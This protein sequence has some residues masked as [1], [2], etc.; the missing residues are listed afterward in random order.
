[1]RQEIM[2]RECIGGEEH[3]WRA[4]RHTHPAEAGYDGSIIETDWCAACGLVRVRT[5]KSRRL[6][7]EWYE[8][9]TPDWD[10][11][12]ER[13][14]KSEA[15]W[16]ALTEA[17]WEGFTRA[18]LPLLRVIRDHAQEVRRYARRGP[19]LAE[20]VESA[21]ADLD[22]YDD[23]VDAALDAAESADAAWEAARAG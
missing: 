20:I 14:P 5:W 7:D 4:P 16:D 12:A 22:G 1:M 23:L 3:V 6:Q 18:I 10:V 11:L 17:V 2:E 19:T 9:H 13:A 8:M 15:A 21:A